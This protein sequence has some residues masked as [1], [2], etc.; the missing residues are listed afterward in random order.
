MRKTLDADGW[1]GERVEGRKR[2]KKHRSS[3]KSGAAGDEKEGKLHGIAKWLQNS[4]QRRAA[5]GA[6][7][8]AGASY[9]S[10][11]EN[12]WELRVGGGLKKKS[13]TMRKIMRKAGE[14]EGM[15]GRAR[16]TE[17]RAGHERHF[18]WLAWRLEEGNPNCRP[19]DTRID[20]GETFDA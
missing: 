13:Q 16:E 8:R 20:S 2:G 14:R 17:T 6:R 10:S 1:M 18:S 3:G 5:K 9:L 19:L 4:R 7:K 15:S 11:M 12:R